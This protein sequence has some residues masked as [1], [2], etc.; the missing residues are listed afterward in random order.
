MNMFNAACQ[1]SVGTCILRKQ[2]QTALR[3]HAC[4]LQLF[5]S[6]IILGKHTHLTSYNGARRPQC[7][8]MGVY[9]NLRDSICTDT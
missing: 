2:M 3:M 9:I 1:Y 7:K 6:E 8:P 5:T 4:A